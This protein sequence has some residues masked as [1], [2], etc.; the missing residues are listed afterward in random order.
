[1][2]VCILNPFKALFKH[3]DVDINVAFREENRNT[4]TTVL[5]GIE[6]SSLSLFF[7]LYYSSPTFH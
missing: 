5:F 6:I 7:S 2:F 4:L 3:E 1:M